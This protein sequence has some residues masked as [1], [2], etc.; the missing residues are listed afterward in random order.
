MI[1]I[2]WLVSKYPSV[3]RSKPLLI[4]TG[5]V[6]VEMREEAHKFQNI[7]LANAKLYISYGTHHTKMMILKYKHGLRV[8]I[9]TANLIEDDWSQKTQG[10]F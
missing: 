6:D 4:V 2:E 10:Y 9:H 1:D 8:V 7:T 5:G 3:S